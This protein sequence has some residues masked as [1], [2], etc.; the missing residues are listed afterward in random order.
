[1]HILFLLASFLMLSGCVKDKSTNYKA[2]WENPTP[3]Y[4]SIKGYTNGLV[5]PGDAVELGTGEETLV[6][7]GSFKGKT[8]GFLLDH[9]VSVDSVIV[10][11]DNQ[12]TVVHYVLAIPVAPA[13]K[14]YPK[15]SGRNLM[16]F[17]SY[18]LTKEPSRGYDNIYSY[19][20]TESEFEFAK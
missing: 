4:I 16:N 7:A 11:F 9:F 8:E 3:H 17:T 14:S 2:T 20:F 15:S 13:L 5:L 6:G 12:Y 18:L 1:M 19:V 10:Q